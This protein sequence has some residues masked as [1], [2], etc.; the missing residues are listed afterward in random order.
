LEDPESLRKTLAMGA[1]KARYVAIKT[2]RKVRKK[3]GLN[4]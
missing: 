1:E 3:G 2:L 4:Y